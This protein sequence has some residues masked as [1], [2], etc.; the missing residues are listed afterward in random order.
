MFL[1]INH[2]EFIFHH[3]TYL[4]VYIILGRNKFYL[5]WW[6]RVNPGNNRTSSTHPMCVRLS[7][8]RSEYIYR[9]KCCEQENM[10]EC[11]WMCVCVC[12][13]GIYVGISHLRGVLVCLR[14]AFVP[15]SITCYAHHCAC[16][17][18]L[19]DPEIKIRNLLCPG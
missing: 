17:F 15:H 11:E 14:W 6:K 3:S 18:F 1:V 2:S 16:N 7:V 10:H 5:I 12:I 9:Y 4:S 13:L 19:W 8:A